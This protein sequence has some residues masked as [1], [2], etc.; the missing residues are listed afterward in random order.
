MGITDGMTLQNIDLVSSRI[1]TTSISANQEDGCGGFLWVALVIDK[2]GFNLFEN[3]NEL[4]MHM[5]ASLHQY[6]T[7]SR[8]RYRASTLTSL[9]LK[10]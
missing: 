3:A 6:Y 10:H 8:I 5:E 7:S 4:D 1:Q 2:K 9:S